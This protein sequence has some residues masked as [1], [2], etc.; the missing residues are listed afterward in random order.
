MESTQR[1]DANRVLVRQIY[2]NIGQDIIIQSSTSFLRLGGTENSPWKI[3]YIQIDLDHKYG[4]VVRRVD[5]NFSI[6]YGYLTT[7]NSF[8]IANS[9]DQS[10]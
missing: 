10:D 2:V 3:L 8:R 1:V 4:G 5:I 6:V 7:N 9:K